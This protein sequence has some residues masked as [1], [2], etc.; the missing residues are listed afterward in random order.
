M[1]PSFLSFRKLISFLF[2]FKTNLTSYFVLFAQ[3]VQAAHV[4]KKWVDY[5]HSKLK[6]K[7]ARQVSA[8]K[9]L[10]VAVKKNKDLTLKITEAER[11]RKNVEAALAGAEK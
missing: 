9:N 2:F 7:E 1:L 8:V 5:V 4:A 3:A 10:V 11:E 6:D